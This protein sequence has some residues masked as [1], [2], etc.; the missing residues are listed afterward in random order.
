[1][2]YRK[3]S[4][5]SSKRRRRAR[6]ERSAVPSETVAKVPPGQAAAPPA[7]S[8]LPGARRTKGMSPYSRVCW[9][10]EQLKAGR[11]WNVP[12]LMKALGI[13]ESSARRDLSHLR[14]EFQQEIDFDEALNSYVLVNPDKPLP[15]VPVTRGELFML[16]MAQGSPRRA[17]GLALRA[18]PPDGRRKAVRRRR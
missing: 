4:E 12:D 3:K 15:H 1:M 7:K 14:I 17:R 11:R 8:V 18:H 5:K 13:S 10:Y 9:I 2:A 6:Q 16:L